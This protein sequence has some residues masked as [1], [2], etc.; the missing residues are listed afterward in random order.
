MNT[1]T[2]TKRAIFLE[3]QIANS[4]LAQVYVDVFKSLYKNIIITYT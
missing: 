1:F 2:N 3:E 4:S